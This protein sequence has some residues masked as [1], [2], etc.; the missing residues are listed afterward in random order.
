MSTSVPHD[1]DVSTKSCAPSSSELASGLEGREWSKGESRASTPARHAWE[2]DSYRSD[3]Q[4]N[5]DHIIEVAVMELEANPD[6]PLRTIARKAGVGQGTLYRHFP[7]R[8]A[9][10][11]TVHQREVDRL[12]VAGGELLERLSP[13]CAL[14]EWMRQL[15][16]FASANPDVGLAMHRSFARHGEPTSPVHTSCAATLGALLAAN[17]VAGTVRPDIARE[18]LLL[19]LA[20]VW[21]V[22]DTEP[23]DRRARA[24]R[25]IDI[26]IAGIAADRTVPQDGSGQ[27]AGDP[28]CSPQG[29]QQHAFD[30]DHRSPAAPGATGP[31][32]GTNAAA[33]EP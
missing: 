22:N 20:G 11:W 16:D 28:Q 24:D 27:S 17:Q 9:L 2:S 1:V 7:D 33:D 30:N 6:V 19:A 21:H 13:L 14:E 26:V 18:D 15:A 4:R 10:L 12:T 25:L 3:A 32:G 8:Q 29:A 31:T 23:T 5:R